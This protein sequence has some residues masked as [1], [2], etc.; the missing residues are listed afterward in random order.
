MFAKVVLFRGRKNFSHAFFDFVLVLVQV[1]CFLASEF[2][3]RFSDTCTTSELLIRQ[4]I[5]TVTIF[6][7]LLYDFPTFGL[8]LN[9]FHDTLVGTSSQL[10]CQLSATQIS[11][12]YLTHTAEVSLRWKHK[13]TDS[14]SCFG[15]IQCVGDYHRIIMLLRFASRLLT[16]ASPL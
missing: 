11:L 9:P 2:H 4:S 10:P 1:P 15:D 13:R 14:F 6:S 8:L 5:R 12:Q 3:V 16:R 7:T